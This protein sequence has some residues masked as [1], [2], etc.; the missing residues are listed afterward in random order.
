VVAAILDAP[1]Q[2]VMAVLA[3][4]V[5]SDVIC[6]WCFIGSRRL[7]QALASLA[8]AVPAAEVTYRPFLL[9][10]STPPQGAD[11]RERLRAKYGVE[12]EMMFARVEQAARSSGIPLDFTKVRRTPSTI[13]AHTLLRHAIAKGTQR[14]L[15]TAL[16]EAYFLE[17]R[18][19]GEATVLASLGAKH[20]F[21]AD[22][23]LAIVRDESQLELTREEAAD[24]AAKGIRGVPFFIFARRFAV[25]GAQAPEVLRAA[26]Q[27][28]ASVASP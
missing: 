26:V 13:A 24:A 9:D 12:P 28:A 25:S 21:D 18:D 4:D 16:F 20:G 3:I 7:D 1:Y 27:R 19:V 10:P 23:A 2:K 14:A 5:V 6:P 8:G 17:G 22:E 11:L 15:A